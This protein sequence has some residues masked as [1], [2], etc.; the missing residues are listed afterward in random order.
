MFLEGMTSEEIR[1]KLIS[2]R[3]ELQKRE[4]KILKTGCKKALRGKSLFPYRCYELLTTKNGN[5]YLMGIELNDA[6]AVIS[7]RTAK[8]AK[9]CKGL[10][11]SKLVC[12]FRYKDGHYG[13]YHPN[14]I[15]PDYFIE[16]TYHFL[17]RYAERTNIIY[18][19][20]IDII[21][22]YF[23]NNTCIVASNEYSDE[24]L[25]DVKSEERYYCSCRDGLIPMLIDE[26]R[27]INICLTFMNSDSLTKVKK[28][29]D[30]DYNDRVN[31]LSTIMDKDSFKIIKRN[32]RTKYNAEEA[33]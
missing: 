15:C 30:C 1:K 4:F 24:E 19:N 16:M 23:N 20:E 22:E 12:V 3:K 13:G 17:L 2:D 31:R 14:V 11:F 28:K 26:K 32:N 9:E 33:I 6:N 27:K 8:S 10:A 25:N 7:G 5:Q 21:K 29:H 18:N